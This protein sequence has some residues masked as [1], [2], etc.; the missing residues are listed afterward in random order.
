MMSS[1]AGGDRDGTADADL[2]RSDGDRHDDEPAARGGAAPGG[3]WI[4][5]GA[6]GGPWQGPGGGWEDHGG[7][8]TGGAGRGWQRDGGRGGERSGA[9][10]RRWVFLLAAG[11]PWIAV[12]AFLLMGG[13]DPSPD[14]GAP[15]DAPASGGGTEPSPEAT[16]EAV[17]GAP[18]AGPAAPD[19]GPRVVSTGARAAMDRG[20][21]AAAAMPVARAWITGIGPRVEVVGL[22]PPAD[23]F[24][25]HLVVEAV[26]L[27]APG[28]AVVTLLAVMLR[29]DGED[30]H[31]AEVRRMAVPL[32]ID[33]ARVAPAGAPWWLEGPDLTVAPLPAG[34]PVDDTDLLVEAGAAL[35]AAGYR[36]VEVTELATTGTWPLVATVTAAAPGETARATHTVWLRRHLDRL[37]VAGTR[38]PPT[39]AAGTEPG[40]ADGHTSREP[41]AGPDGS[42]DTGANDIT[43]EE[44]R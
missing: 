26:D 30:Y 8:W 14:A 10:T 13:G 19:G 1:P 42:S 38:P 24:A 29:A 4:E 25:D 32:R 36:E 23:R 31:A 35:S 18:P 22:D 39:P 12:A 15:A 28:A 16:Q 5:D 40:G 37:V 27:P 3:G 7:G 43:T 34:E 9:D 20:E 17:A 21:I 11:V 6:W 33:G 41:E 44:P 2:P